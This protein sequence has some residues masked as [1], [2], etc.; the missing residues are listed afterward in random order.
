MHLGA[1]SR[2]QRAAGPWRGWAV[3][4]A[5]TVPTGVTVRQVP[6]SAECF[7][8]ME[9]LLDHGGTAVVLDLEPVLGV[10]IAAALSR[11]QVA[12]VVL[13]LP[14]WPHADAVLPVHDLVAALVETSRHLRE[15]NV[16]SNVVFVLDAER[17]KSV[18]RPAADGRV[19]NRYSLSVGDLPDLVTLRRAGIGR[20]VKLVQAG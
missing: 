9:P 16:I 8:E 14:R 17:Q 13:V 1:W 3:C 2:W 12:Y 11:R 7:R 20:V 15:P 18:R 10:R 6:P 5:L 4:P 19:D